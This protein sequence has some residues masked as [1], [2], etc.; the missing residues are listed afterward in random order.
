MCEGENRRCWLFKARP[1][2]EFG[3]G[4]T[5]CLILG[6]GG[7]GG[8][9]LPHLVC[10]KPFPSEK[11]CVYGSNPA[12][13]VREG[14][15]FP[16][17]GVGAPRMHKASFWS[18]DPHPELNSTNFENSPTSILSLKLQQMFAFRRPLAAGIAGLRSVPGAAELPRVGRLSARPVWGPRVP[19][20]EG[21]AVLLGSRDLR[22]VPGCQ[23][24]RVPQRPAPGPS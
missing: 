23:S 16:L 11:G 17:P 19:D 1:S 20:G 4:D 15:H 12:E 5:E 2:S 9:S 18:C 14:R 10:V 24:W 6:P 3:R 13:M 22:D 7:G 8:K 21:S